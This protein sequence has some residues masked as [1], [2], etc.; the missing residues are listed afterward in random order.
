MTDVVAFCGLPSRPWLNRALGLRRLSR[1]AVEF[2]TLEATDPQTWRAG[3]W[4]WSPWTLKEQVL[5]TFMVLGAPPAAAASLR[6]LIVGATG[7]QHRCKDHRYWDLARTLDGSALRAQLLD[8][9]TDQAESTR[10]RARFVL[11]LL[12]HPQHR[13]DGRGWWQWLRTEGRPLPDRLA[14]LSVGS[15]RRPADAA[16][17]LIGVP[18]PDVAVVLESLE[19]GPAIQIVALLEPAV[20]AGA[21]SGMDRLRAAQTLRRLPAPAAA[22]ILRHLA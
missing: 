20:A 14:R 15:L 11:W 21:L 12:E 1:A 2:L 3:P 5:R 13:T 17:A 10:L 9:A 19:F 22:A 18:A 4:P 6:D 7:R 16:A 8:A